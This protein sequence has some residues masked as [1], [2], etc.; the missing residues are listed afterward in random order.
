MDKLEKIPLYKKG[1]PHKPIYGTDFLDDLKPTW[2]EEWGFKSPFGK[3]RKIMVSKP[4]DEQKDSLISEDPQFFNLPEGLTNLNKLQEEHRRLVAALEAEGIEV[5]YL[6]SK[7]PFKGTYGIPLRSA[8]YTME[9]IMVRGGAVIDRP[10]VAYK[11]GIEVFHAKRLMELGCPILHT[12]HGKGVYEAGNVGWIDDKSVILGMGLR[13]NMEGLSQVESIL[14]GLGVEDIHIAHLPGYLH[15][16]KYQVGGSSG[17]FHL[18]MTFKMAYYKLGV[19]WPGG[20]GYDTI[21]WLEN[22]DVDLIEVTDEELQTGAVNLLPIAPNKV[23][24]PAFNAR[25]TKELKK[26]GMDVIEIDLSEFVKGG[27]GPHC[28]TLPLIRD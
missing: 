12:I 28:L 6:N 14:R 9:T 16:R 20:I 7:E 19:V 24:I 26:R 4:G 18:D 10:A 2:G 13:G 22:K 21:L 1:T 27:G 8:P 5:V 23:I 25:V 15:T 17:I 11:K 3:I